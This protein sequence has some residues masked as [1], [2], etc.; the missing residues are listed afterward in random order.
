MCLSHHPV[1]LLFR[2]KKNKLYFEISG[3]KKSI[4]WDQEKQ[5]ELWIGYRDGAN[6]ILLKDPSLLQSA[7]AKEMSHYPAGHNEGWF[8]AIVNVFCDIYSHILTGNN[9]GNYATFRD[10]LNEILLCEAILESHKLNKKIKINYG[11]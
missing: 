3:S 6:Q 4:A 7:V 9:N 1:L 5:N 8:D 11:V 2:Q 10:G